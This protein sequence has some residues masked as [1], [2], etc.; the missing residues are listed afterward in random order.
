MMWEM[1]GLPPR[2]TA[3]GRTFLDLTLLACLV[4][5][6]ATGG[7][8][9]WLHLAYIVV[10]LRAFLQNGGWPTALRT[11]VV[12]VVGGALLLRLH[13]T[14]DATGHDL[15]QI[16]LLA[17][18]MY[19][20][21]AFAAQRER[22]E[23][24]VARDRQHLEQL[25]DRLPLATIVFGE[26]A[27][28]LTWNRAAEALFGWRADEVI[29]D[30]NPI[31]ADNERARSDELYA[32][33]VAGELTGPIEALR[34]TRDGRVL[35][36]SLHGAT[37]E[38]GPG[39]GTGLLVMYEDIGE[40]RQAERQRDAAESRYRGLIESL[41]GVTYVDRIDPATHAETNVYISPQL[42][43]L[44]GWLPD[45][46][47]E[48]PDAYESMLHPDDAPH[49]IAEV[50]RS[51]EERTS[52]DFEYRIRHKNGSYVWVHD[53]R[54][55]AE[56]V[57]GERLARGFAVDLTQRKRLEEQ[58]LQSQKMDAIGQFA[59]GIAHDFNNLLTAIS[60]YADLA[61]TRTPPGGNLARFLD[62]IRSAATEAAGLTSQLLSFS[63]HDVIERYLV[64]LNEIA[65]GTAELLGRLLRDDVLM[66]LELAEPLPPVSGDAVQ[67]KQV[68]LNLALNARDAMADGGTLT[69]E[70]ALRG[71]TVALR[72]HDT[73]RGMD[74]LTR[75]HAFEP[76]YT[77]KPEGEGTGLGLS[78]VFGVIDSLGG[79][80]SVD[81]S[82][83][84]GTTVEVL[85]PAAEGVAEPDPM[86]AAA[87]QGSATGTGTGRILLVEDREIVRELTTEVLR[88]AGFDV[89]VATNG[90]E[91]LELAELSDPFDLLLTD[92]VMAELSGPELAERLRAADPA[93]RVLYMSGYT[94]DVLE[95]ADLSV[96]GTAFI[97]KP[98]QTAHLI[99]LVDQHLGHPAG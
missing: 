5:L 40:R 89:A 62:G 87:G 74:E 25:V 13:A 78:V 37:L 71:D 22:E 54:A 30:K 21:A 43:E 77:T 48:T 97:R 2:L 90:R 4:V 67:L 86:L 31:V 52:F 83:G 45:D 16:P 19:L 56:D 53:H 96:P 49:V 73:G 12:S 26:G 6:W 10:A 47:V 64:D 76:F 7:V 36:L 84:A 94:D 60:G 35:E 50:R 92:V 17:V 70:T 99:A 18:L 57:G 72:V 32:R 44:L 24:G 3:V 23:Q 91:A 59:G 69:I 85:L 82:P 9:L 33:A 11:T 27:K 81:S 41:P 88:T 58:L 98:F 95:A 14:G 15:L 29:G 80:V 28:V 20:F 55:V 34:R 51:N 93:L 63:R 75:T 42:T 66:R 65:R 39:D 68:V 1:T 46:W 79:S 8:T 38:L 61:A